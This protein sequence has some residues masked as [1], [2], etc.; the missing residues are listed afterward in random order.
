M[1]KFRECPHC[2]AIWGQ[3]EID[4]QECG[5]CGYPNNEIDFE[6]EEEFMILIKHV[7]NAD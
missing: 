5:A 1:S 3:E 7:K 6:P 4:F 2:P